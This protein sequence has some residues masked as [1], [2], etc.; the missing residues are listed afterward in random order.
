MTSTVHSLI[1]NS[2]IQEYWEG[3]P[4]F[5]SF[6]Q[7]RAKE[8]RESQAT[9]I[10]PV[11]RVI[12]YSERKIKHPTIYYARG[13]DLLS[14]CS[15]LE[16]TDLDETIAEAVDDRLESCCGDEIGSDSDEDTDDRPES[17]SRGAVKV[18]PYDER[19]R[20]DS[21]D[22]LQTYFV[23]EENL[24]HDRRVWWKNLA[25]AM[26]N[27]CPK[28]ITYF[29]KETGKGLEGWAEL[30]NRTSQVLTVVANC[31]SRNIMQYLID[32]YPDK[33]RPMANP[34]ESRINT[35][36]Y[37]AIGN[38]NYKIAEIILPYT[39]KHIIVGSNGN[40]ESLLHDVV[41]R[42]QSRLAE[43]L[44]DSPM[45]T[46]LIECVD[47]HGMTALHAAAQKLEYLTFK[48]VYDAYAS[49][50]QLMSR[51]TKG[52]Y[53]AFHVLVQTKKASM[54]QQFVNEVGIESPLTTIADNLGLTPL[55]WIARDGPHEVLDSLYSIYAQRGYLFAKTKNDECTFFAYL[56]RGKYISAIQQLME[57]PDFDLNLVSEVDAHGF[58]PAMWADKNQ[59]PEIYELLSEY[60]VQPERIGSFC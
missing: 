3:D 25:K 30:P 19:G 55:H 47:R 10:E 23:P 41:N 26:S 22:P 49:S 42:G 29:L 1:P 46:D 58:T 20:Y 11:T 35:P 7:R 39:E 15:L 28:L 4:E 21:D 9:P 60:H 34:K 50:A 51:C 44:I 38:F 18:V 32:A 31:N 48:R 17:Y 37:T 8:H 36:L 12:K 57:R 54:I 43:M 52:G 13:S 5:A 6:I 59:Q 27:R 40:C 45:I 33:I 14:V 53:T 2:W 56:V 16:S 24:L